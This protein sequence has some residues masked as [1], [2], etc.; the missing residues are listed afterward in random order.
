[1]DEPQPAQKH[2]RMFDECGAMTVFA[3]VVVF[4]FVLLLGILTHLVLTRIDGIETERALK[5]GL[6]SA[7]SA[8]EP[9]L[10]AYGLFAVRTNES[11]SNVYEST[12]RR[13]LEKN[14]IA[15]VRVEPLEFRYPLADQSIFE[16]QIL[17]SMR[18]IAPLEFTRLLAEPAKPFIPLVSVARDFQLESEEL[19]RQITIREQKMDEFSNLLRRLKAAASSAVETGKNPESPAVSDSSGI[20]TGAQAAVRATY[21]ESVRAIS[22][23]E[24]AD[25]QIDDTVRRQMREPKWL[26]LGLQDIW[27]T[28]PVYG[29]FPFD[30]MRTE[31]ASAVAPVL[32]QSTA[33]SFQEAVDRLDGLAARL[34]PFETDRAARNRRHREIV[35][36]KKQ[37]ALIIQAQAYS[38]A[39]IGCRAED[40]AVYERLE[41]PGGKVDRILLY[42]ELPEHQSDQRF[43]NPLEQQPDEAAR[44]MTFRLRN[45]S[46]LTKTVRDQLY[47]NEFALERFNRRTSAFDA[48]QILQNQET[49]YILYGMSSCQENLVLAYGETFLFRAIVGAVQALSDPASRATA[50]S[51]VALFW[52]ALAEGFSAARKDMQILVSGGSVP[53]FGRVAPIEWTYKDHLR[54]FFLL[55]GSDARTIARM[56][57]LIE[58]NTGIDLFQTATYLEGRVYASVK[59][60]PIAAAWMRVSQ[61]KEEKR[62]E[63]RVELFR[64]AH[65]SY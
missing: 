7:L 21:A 16:R 36:G 62:D 32:A 45:L 63:S 64:T 18:Y 51:P 46:E 11:I 54:L 10:A 56:Q 31:L 39:R 25:K 24:Q 19:H 60:N 40:A 53:L 57:A 4:S 43:V 47:L 59:P 55:H 8:F 34:Q 29:A 26:D 5:A 61:K 35:D 22:E 37:K 42:N 17:E 14:G 15:P 50:P 65:A 12:V 28:I 9:A 30:Q 13:N 1:M 48:K 38:A 20:L 2:G 41:S 23:A 6:R 44:S 27:R 52:T 58:T 49:E 3:I 33:E